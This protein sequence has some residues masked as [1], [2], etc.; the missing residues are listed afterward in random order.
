M[1]KGSWFKVHGYEVFESHL[2]VLYLPV[3]AEVEMKM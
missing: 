3:L 2:A 1:V